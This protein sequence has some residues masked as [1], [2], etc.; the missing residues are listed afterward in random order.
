MERK[1]LRDILL[2]AVAIIAIYFLFERAGTVLG[3]MKTL[4]AILAP[5]VMGGCF[6]FIL[7]VPMRFFERH[8][9]RGM[10]R[11]KWSAKLKRPLAMTLTLAL[12]LAAVYLLLSMVLPELARTIVTIVKGVPVF[13]ARLNEWLLKYGFDLS[14]YLTTSVLPSTEQMNT[15][16]NDILQIML[17]G[18]VFSTSVIGTLY[19]NVL[20]VFFTVMFSIYFLS[21]K[22]RLCSQSKRLM[23]AYLDRRR[24]DRML[25]VGVLAQ[26]TFSSFITGQC[27]EA[28]ILGGLFFFCMTVFRMPYVM[29]IS[30]LIAVTALIPVIGAWIGCIVGALLILLV[31]PMQ[32]VWFVVMFLVVQQLE[33]NLI[34]PHVMGNAIGLPSIWVLFAVVLG[35][36][37]MGIIGMLLFIP[38]ASVGYTLLRERV[39]VRLAQRG[40]DED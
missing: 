29:L 17:K 32:A 13:V 10:E 5:F 9:L 24:V 36:G 18:A 27:L 31:N 35:E 6:A 33:G 1:K 28:I 11:A 40:L 23:Y 2:L 3:F 20:S 21:A 7:N 16:V 22:E 12:V 15:R 26:H 30:L 39:K 4:L 8:I 37:L 14:Q 19:Q 38:L 25:E 34:Y